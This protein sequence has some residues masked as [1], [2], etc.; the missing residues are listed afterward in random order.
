MCSYVPPFCIQCRNL[1]IYVFGTTHSISWEKR[2]LRISFLFLE[3]IL[4][5][6]SLCQVWEYLI[7]DKILFRQRRAGNTTPVNSTP[8]VQHRITGTN[9]EMTVATNFASC[10]LLELCIRNRVPCQS[11]S[12]KQVCPTQVTAVH[13]SHLTCQYGVSLQGQQR[14]HFLPTVQFGTATASFNREIIVLEDNIHSA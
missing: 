1:W 4:P 10:A 12:G 3:Q 9:N 7:H 8:T 5:K 14:H 6:W 2:R 13:S 11:Y